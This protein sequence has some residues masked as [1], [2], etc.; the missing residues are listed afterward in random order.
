[1]VSVYYL[2]LLI[3]STGLTVFYYAIMKKHFSVYMTLLF[4]IIPI[5]NVG[6]FLF[7]MSQSKEAALMAE[8]ISYLGGCFVG[9]LLMVCIMEWC[10]ME[11][12]KLFKLVY[13]FVSLGM[14]GLA[15]TN[16][17]VRDIFYAETYF[18]RVDDIVYLERI[19]GTFLWAYLA[20]N[21]IYVIMNVIILLYSIGKQKKAPR[22]I[23]AIMLAYQVVYL[24][25]FFGWKVMNMQGIGNAFDILPIGYI[26]L[27]IVLFIILFRV[28]L[29]KLV[30]VPGEGFEDR[31]NLA[32]ISFDN[33]FRY[34]GANEDAEIMFSELEDIAVDSSAKKSPFFKKNIAG[35]LEE[36]KKDSIGTFKMEHYNKTYAVD[37]DHLYENEK[38]KGYRVTLW[39]DKNANNRKASAEEPVLE[40][41]VFEEPN[42]GESNYGGSNFI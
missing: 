30:P 33:G 12:N 19:F 28:E 11:V 38:I 2:I 15:L 32:L 29:Y 41:P 25:D 18:E 37:V 4:T 26:V 16:G 8:K 35:W 34:L 31:K 14:Y 7:S 17:Y 13:F 6:F 20:M 39:E 24:W 10:K 40:E 3:V 42:Y 23:I 22:I 21:L 1:M 5:S 9:Y 27:Q 36:F